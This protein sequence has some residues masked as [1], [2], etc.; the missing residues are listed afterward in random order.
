MPLTNMM[1]RFGPESDRRLVLCAHW[2]TRPWCDQDPDSSW[3]D[4]PVP[5]ANDPG[6]GVAVLL[7]LAELFAKRPPPATVELVFFDGEDQGRAT[8]SEEF[9]LGSKYWAEA[10]PKGSVL[11][12]FLFDM[13]GD[14]DLEISPE[15]NSMQHAANLVSLVLEAARNTGARSFRDTPRYQ[16]VDDHVRLLNVGIPAVDIIDF[17]YPS[18][19]TH[20]DTPDKTSPESLAEVGRVAAWLAYKSPMVRGDR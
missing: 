20:E 4:D 17:D 13:V 16:L 10:Q 9:C 7:E 6:S 18:W 3:H 11:G 1:A 5:G 14:R 19:H 15:R 8:V 2:D 12:A